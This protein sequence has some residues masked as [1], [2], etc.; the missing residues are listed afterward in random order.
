MARLL[1]PRLA[2]SLGQPVVVDNKPG[3]GGNLGAADGGVRR[4]M[5]TPC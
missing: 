4:R 3:A 5:A 1:G 2:Q